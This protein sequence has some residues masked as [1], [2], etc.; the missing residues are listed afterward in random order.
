MVIAAPAASSARPGHGERRRANACCSS[1]DLSAAAGCARAASRAGSEASE[2]RHRDAGDGEHAG[3]HRIDHQRA[4]RRRGSSRHRGRRRRRAARHRRARSHRRCPAPLP[5]RP[6][7]RAFEHEPTRERRA[8]V[9]PSVRNSAK[10]A[11]R[12]TTDSA[13]VENTSKAPGEQGDERQDVEVDAVGARHAGG[14]GRVVLRRRD[15]D[16]GRKQRRD[17]CAHGVRRRAWPHAKIDARNDAAAREEILRRRDVHHARSARRSTL[18]RALRPRARCRC[19]PA[20]TRSVSPSSIPSH[21]AAAGVTNTI[22]G[23]QD[24]EG[25]RAVADERRRDRAARKA[26]TP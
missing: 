2:R 17:P 7:E 3:R 6:D 13:C 11:R 10:C 18:R 16:A 8:R 14:R 15:R 1:P 9:M 22:A 20:C 21:D 25:S 24:V 5:R 19:M 12:R 4:A 26:S 23:A